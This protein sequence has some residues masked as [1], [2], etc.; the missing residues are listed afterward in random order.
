MFDE[1][2]SIIFQH[3]ATSSV[4][5]WPQ[6]CYSWEHR[7]RLMQSSSCP[8]RFRSSSFQRTEEPDLCAD[9]IHGDPYSKIT[10]ALLERPAHDSPAHQI[11][12]PNVAHRSW[13][14]KRPD[15]ESSQ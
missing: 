15:V 4:A 12:V 6:W 3:S 13:P 10:F 1:A 9:L 5:P 7:R 2:Q 11:R 14:R 8:A